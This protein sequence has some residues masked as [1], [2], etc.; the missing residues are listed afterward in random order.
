MTVSDGSDTAVRRRWGDRRALFDDQ[1][2]TQLVFVAA[3]RCIARRGPAR[4][5]RAEVA[6]EGGSLVA[7][8]IGPRTGGG[9]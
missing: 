8:E 1:V 6:D 3:E 4:V 7:G 2:A 5:A 9:R